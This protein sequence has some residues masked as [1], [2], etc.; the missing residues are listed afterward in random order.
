MLDIALKEWAVVCD[1]LLDG[2][3]ALLLRKGGIHE[4]GGPGVFELEHPRFLLYPTWAHQK[5]EMVK[6]EFRAGVVV[7][8]EPGTVT[9]AG[10]AEVGRIWP[11]KDRAAFDLLN[12]LH[13]WTSEQID[14]RF[15]Y[16][17]EH[18]LY[19]MAVRAYWLQRPRT[20]A[21]TAAYGG[22]RSWVPLS[23]A[24]AVDDVGAVPVLADTAFAAVV[25]RVEKALKP[26]ARR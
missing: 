5:P 4:S 19:L 15:N 11:V 18:P 21:N 14:M 8:A 26:G 10:L 9:V 20:L 6:P 12:G 3:L 24:D 16:K 22:C 25:A 23:P 17:P 7:Q 1:L 13:C 2:R